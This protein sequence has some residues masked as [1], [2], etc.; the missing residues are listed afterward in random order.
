[1]GTPIEFKPV[2]AR[3]QHT[4]DLGLSKYY[5]VVYYAGEWYSYSGSKTFNDG[6]TVVDWTYCEYCF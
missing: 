6:E 3:I 5:E 4:N 2:L 1:M